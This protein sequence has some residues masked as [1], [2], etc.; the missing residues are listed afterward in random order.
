LDYSGIAP[1]NFAVYF[2]MHYV[3]VYDL[4]SE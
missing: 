1:A 3:E 2:T 4:D